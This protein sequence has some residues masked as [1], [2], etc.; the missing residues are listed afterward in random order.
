[1]LLYVYF[2]AMCTETIKVHYYL[3]GTVKSSTQ[4]SQSLHHTS[5]AV[6]LDSIERLYTRQGL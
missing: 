3:A 2:V 6:A 1:M 4:L 5:A